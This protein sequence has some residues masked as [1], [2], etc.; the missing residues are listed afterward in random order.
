MIS[1][2]GCESCGSFVTYQSKVCV[3]SKAL[4]RSTL[5]Q[6]DL[7]NRLGCLPARDR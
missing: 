2:T 5:G 6:L 4:I 1:L 3:S 7:G